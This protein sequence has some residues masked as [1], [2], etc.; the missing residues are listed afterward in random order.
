MELN[1]NIGLNNNIKLEQIPNVEKTLKDNNRNKNSNIIEK[2]IKK[3]IKFD[4]MNPKNNME[5][6]IDKDTNIVYTSIKDKDSGK[7]IR[8]IPSKLFI[9]LSKEIIEEQERKSSTFLN[10]K[11]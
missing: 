11:I 4:I 1:N 10:I 5:Y 6:V 9:E 8:T 7:E 2:D 3:E